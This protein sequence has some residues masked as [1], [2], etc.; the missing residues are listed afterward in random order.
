M[1]PPALFQ[2]SLRCRCAA[3][4]P[5]NTFLVRV[6][7]VLLGFSSGTIFRGAESFEVFSEK[8]GPSRT[9]THESFTD[10]SIHSVVS[11]IAPSPG[12][13]DRR[14][15]GHP[16]PWGTGRGG[17]GPAAT[18]R[19]SCEFTYVALFK[20]GTR[21]AEQQIWEEG[22]V[23]EATCRIFGSPTFLEPRP[24]SMSLPARD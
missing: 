17:Q 24:L 13:R 2:G 16:L 9:D 12:L 7:V 20:V 18:G 1:Q 23:I 22:H 15:F 21:F 3:P 10:R 6:V 19:H 5:M 14:R 8:G 11:S 4:R